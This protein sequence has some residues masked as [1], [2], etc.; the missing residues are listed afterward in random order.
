MDAYVARIQIWNRTRMRY[1]CGTFAA[2]TARMCHVSG[3]VPRTASSERQASLEAAKMAKKKTCLANFRHPWTKEWVQA[4][5][6]LDKDE[7]RMDCAKIPIAITAQDGMDGGNWECS[8][9]EDVEWR[10]ISSECDEQMY[11]LD[12]DQQ[13]KLKRNELEFNIEILVTA[14]MFQRENLEKAQEEQKTKEAIVTSPGKKPA[15]KPIVAEEVKEPKPKKPRAAKFICSQGDCRTCLIRA[16][17]AARMQYVCIRMWHVCIPSTGRDAYVATYAP[18]MSSVCSTHVTRV[19]TYAGKAFTS[20]AAL[21][22]RCCIRATYA[23]H[24]CGHLATR[25]AH[26]SHTC[27]VCDT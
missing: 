12:R 25:A 2:R 8:F 1:V 21:K 14:S 26:V 3:R 20:D 22:V 4:P 19:W 11:D 27:H 6:D 18:R 9:A 10:A 5:F 15:E 17:H 7:T 13:A 24:V 23:C 16:T